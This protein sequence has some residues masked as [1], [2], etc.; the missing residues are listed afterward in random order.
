MQNFDLSSFLPYQLA[1]LSERVSRE[2]SA[3]YRARYGISRAEW[4]V[5]AHL[6]QTDAVSVR[7]IV[8]WAELEK[9]KVSRA[10]TR[11]ESAGFVTKGANASDRRLV[12]LALTPKGRALMADMAPLAHD[13]ERR[14]LARLGPEAEGFLTAVEKLTQD[15]AAGS[16]M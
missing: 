5:L 9:S 16:P 10:A 4:R 3:I 8:E 15:K 7:D 12:K 11:L 1:V 6:S 13:F 14:V 2:F